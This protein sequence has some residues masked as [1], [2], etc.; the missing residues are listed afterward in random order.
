MIM[1]LTSSILLIEHPTFQ[2]LLAGQLAV[3]LSIID[4]QL[5]TSTYV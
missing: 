3:R 2:L 1:C 5:R 4:V